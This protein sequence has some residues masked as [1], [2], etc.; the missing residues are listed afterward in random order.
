MREVRIPIGFTDLR[1]AI[2]HDSNIATK[3]GFPGVAKRANEILDSLDQVKFKIYKVE[4][5]ITE[6]D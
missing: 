3:E 1:A 6:G 4:I 5:V 2:R